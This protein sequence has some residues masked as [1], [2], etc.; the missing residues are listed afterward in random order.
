MSE[1]IWSADSWNSE[2]MIDQVSAEQLVE[3]VELMRNITHSLGKGVKRRRATREVN[4]FEVV[5]ISD[6]EF[7][8]PG[9]LSDWSAP[10]RKYRQHHE[11]CRTYSASYLPYE[12]GGGA[13]QLVVLEN[14]TKRFID[15]EE[16]PKYHTH[17]NMYRMNWQKDGAVEYARMISGEFVSSIETGVDIRGLEIDDA[18]MWADHEETDPGLFRVFDTGTVPALV[19]SWLHDRT[20]EYGQDFLN[21]RR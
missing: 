12:L 2:G 18:R 7:W 1:K 4:G 21:A 16:R 15:S 11:R 3:Y 8:L 17:R 13:A 10:D 14:D 19:F 6:K 20:S 5:E 9:T